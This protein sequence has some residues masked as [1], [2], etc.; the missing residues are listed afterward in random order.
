MVGWQI[1]K[2]SHTDYALTIGLHSADVTVVD[3]V[4]TEKT[5]DLTCKA[6]QVGLQAIEHVT[7]IAL[8]VHTNIELARQDKAFD[9]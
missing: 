6:I 9:L 2:L 7:G 8:K 3:A 1:K 5:V 4:D